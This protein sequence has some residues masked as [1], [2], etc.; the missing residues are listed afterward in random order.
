MATIKSLLD[1]ALK[2]SST[3]AFPK[4]GYEYIQVLDN[5]SLATSGTYQVDYAYTAPSDGWLHMY[6]ATNDN[7]YPPTLRMSFGNNKFDMNSTKD[8]WGLI[9]TPLLPVAKGDVVRLR[10]GFVTN[11]VSAIFIKKK[12][13]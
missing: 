12:G 13:S 4:V 8:G 6:A 5:A 3:N 7:T 11:S 9:G 2:A 1:T 10:S